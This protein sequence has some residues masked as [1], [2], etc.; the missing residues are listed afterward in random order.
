MKSINSLNNF[1]T[2]NTV[3][4]TWN[5]FITNGANPS[6]RAAHTT[7]ASKVVYGIKYE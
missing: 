7:V 6:G 5:S 1:K 2:Y 3:D 4:G